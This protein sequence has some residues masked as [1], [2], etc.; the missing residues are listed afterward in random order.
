[1]EQIVKVLLVA[2]LLVQMKGARAAPGPS[3]L[4][5]TTYIGETEK[6]NETRHRK[7]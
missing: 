6:N 1:M 4:T 5:Q 7:P 3:T 2:V